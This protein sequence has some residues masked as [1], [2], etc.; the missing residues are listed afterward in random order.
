[1]KPMPLWD[2]IL[3]NKYFI[4]VIRTGEHVGQ[5]N[6]L[7][8]DTQQD[9]FSCEVSLAYG[10]IFGPDVG[11]VQKWCDMGVDF[12]DNKLITSEVP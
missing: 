1:M 8:I 3:D 4:Y 9:V 11:D 5:Y 6:I 2:A 12:V 10:A 7:D